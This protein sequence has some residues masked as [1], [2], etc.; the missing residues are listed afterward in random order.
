MIGRKRSS[1]LDKSHP[2]D[3]SLVA[4]G[5]E[6]EIDHHDR[7]FLDD[8]DQQNDADQGDDTQFGLA[9]AAAPASARRPRR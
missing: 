4:L 6:R 1:R 2:A 3:F 9:Q 8:A 7:V 5:L